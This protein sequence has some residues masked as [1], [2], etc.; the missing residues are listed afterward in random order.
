[1]PPPLPAPPLAAQQLRQHFEKILPLTDE[2]FARLLACF[3]LKRDK[4]RPLLL[5]PGEPVRSYYFVVAGLLKLEVW[6]SWGHQTLE[7][8]LA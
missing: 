3:T 6:G 2:E 7:L 5:R 4:K 1:M 8:R